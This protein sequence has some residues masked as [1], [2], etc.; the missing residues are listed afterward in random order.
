[1]HLGQAGVRPGRGRAQTARVAAADRTPVEHRF[2]GDLAAWWP[3]I[4]AAGGVRRGGRL[5]RLPAAHRTGPADRRPEVL[6]L[7]SGGGNNGLPPEDRFD[8]HPGRSVRGRCW[9]SPGGSIPECEHHAGRHADGPARPRVRRRLVHDAIDYMTTED[10]LARRPSRPRTRTAGRAGSPCSCPTTSPRTSSRAPTT[11]ARRP[12]RPG[13]ALPVLDQRPGPDR[14]RDPTPSTP[15]CS[16][17]PDGTRRRSP[18][19][20]TCSA[21]SPG[22]PGSRLLTEAGFER[23]HVA[24]ITTED[25]QPRVFFVGVRPA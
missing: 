5:R 9:R 12:G 19:T 16:G 8:A 11:A 14:Q 13:R 3:L 15:S 7:G 2:Y 24:E 1:M 6:E 22:R 17:T 10:D 21:C 25:H 20:P 23:P 18:R 4:S